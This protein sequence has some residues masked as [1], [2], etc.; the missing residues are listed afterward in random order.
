MIENLHLLQ[1]DIIQVGSYINK[2]INNRRIDA[3]T[4]QKTYLSG[5]RIIGALGVVFGGLITLSALPAMFLNPFAGA[6]VAALGLV[7]LGVSHDLFVMA[8]NESEQKNPVN[9][10]VAV[11]KTAANHV[12]D[13]AQ[14]KK[15]VEDLPKQSITDGTIFQ[16][17]WDATNLP[18]LIVKA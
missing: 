17:F 16:P 11:V 6:A 15:K 4:E 12:K 13:V 9:K 14:G 1:H 3:Q 5:V 2:K 10:G 8:K 18:Q 7:I